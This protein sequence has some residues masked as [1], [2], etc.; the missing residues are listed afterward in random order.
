M[1]SRHCKLLTTFGLEHVVT[2]SASIS[3]K[4]S[5]NPVI[6]TASKPCPYS[7]F[8]LGAEPAVR[9]SQL[10]KQYQAA[11]LKVGVRVQRRDELSVETKQGQVGTHQAEAWRKE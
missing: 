3:P 7:L 5:E 2:R 11:V 4:P 6:K 8:S 1:T 9:D 10:E